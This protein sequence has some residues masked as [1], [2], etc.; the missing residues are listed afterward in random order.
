MQKTALV[1]SLL[2]ASLMIA[3]APAAAFKLFDDNDK[4]TVSSGNRAVTVD[5]KGAAKVQQKTPRQTSDRSTIK[6]PHVSTAE[7]QRTAV[8]SEGTTTTRQTQAV[9]TVQRSNVT[10]ERST[11][12][13]VPENMKAREFQ[14][15]QKEKSGKK[16]LKSG[17]KVKAKPRAGKGKAAQ[18]GTDTFNK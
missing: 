8:K 3:S 6:S 17:T 12:V 9:R 14:Q 7:Q 15:K 16:F 1:C 5:G 13:N 18:A 10:T 4:V 2:A 11:T